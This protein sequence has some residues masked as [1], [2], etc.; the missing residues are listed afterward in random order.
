MTPFWW[1]ALAYG[2]VLVTLAAYMLSLRRRLRD[3]VRAHGP[4][5]HRAAPVR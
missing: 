1:V 4:S 2:T 3:A 5:A